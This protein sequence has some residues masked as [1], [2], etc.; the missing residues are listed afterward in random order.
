LLQ[1]GNT[2]LD[3]DG[4][5]NPQ[6]YI[7]YE[8]THDD[9]ETGYD[10][11]IGNVIAMERCAYVFNWDYFDDDSGGYTKNYALD[12]YV[13]GIVYNRTDNEKMTD[14]YI[15]QTRNYSIAEGTYRDFPCTVTP[16]YFSPA[17]GFIFYFIDNDGST[18]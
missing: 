1:I 11:Y 5:S 9:G 16:F 8:N 6:H 15:D 17:G 10:H 4:N 14:T 12:R 13:M 3:H 7:A 2:D 18:A